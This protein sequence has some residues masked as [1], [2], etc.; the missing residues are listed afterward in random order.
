MVVS[1][2]A[3]GFSMSK[4]CKNRVALLKGFISAFQVIKSEILFK[5]RTIEEIVSNIELKID[6]RVIEYL[7]NH[8]ISF[9]SSVDITSEKCNIDTINTFDLKEE[10]LSEIKSIIS[11]L[12]NYDS[13]TQSEI[14]D[15]S[16]SR[17]EFSLASAEKEMEKN[18]RLYV[19]IFL[20]I[21]LVFSLILL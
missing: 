16:L 18:S 4:S 10:D 8:I 9:G 3:I 6:N 1:S 11:A 2:S 13:A 19:F 5:N 14:I 20:T 12:G 17:L 15:R 7:K 21:G